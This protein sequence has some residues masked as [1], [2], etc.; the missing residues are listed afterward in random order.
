MQSPKSDEKKEVRIKTVQRRT[1][2]AKGRGD[3]QTIRP[4]SNGNLRQTVTSL[5]K[6]LQA[7][8]G[9]TRSIKAGWMVNVPASNAKLM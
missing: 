1:Q 7:S 3:N 9:T 8:L 5:S 6:K 2:T 4:Q